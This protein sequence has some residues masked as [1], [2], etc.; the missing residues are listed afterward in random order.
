MFYLSHS[1]LF[2]QG[3]KIVFVIE[4]Y[5]RVDD[6]NKYFMIIKL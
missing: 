2:I 4:K 6:I 5:S 3:I 1:I